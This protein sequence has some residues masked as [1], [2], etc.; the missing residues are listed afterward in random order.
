MIYSSTRGC[1]PNR[2][3]AVQIDSIEPT[4][5]APVPKR[6]RLNYDELLSNLCRLTLSN[7]RWRR[8]ELNSKRLKQN[9]HKLLSSFAFYYNLRR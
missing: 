7:P 5:K 8:L 2:G 9:G 4:L 6:L 1:R 3:M